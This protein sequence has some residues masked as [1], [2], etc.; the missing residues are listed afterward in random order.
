M[1]T[2]KL[3]MNIIYYEYNTIIKYTINPTRA[4]TPHLQDL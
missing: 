1:G 3:S 2:F 4:Y